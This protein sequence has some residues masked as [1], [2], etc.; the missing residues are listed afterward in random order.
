VLQAR[1]WNA[2]LLGRAASVYARMALPA[3]LVLAAVVF[4]VELAY[5]AADDTP[6]PMRI[7]GI[8]I[9]STAAGSW[10]ASLALLAISIALARW[11]WRRAAPRWAEIES[12][13]MGPRA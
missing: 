13:L 10:I 1:L 9:D 3:A 2:R 7:L 6:A 12:A 8:D 11:A 5:K 4:L